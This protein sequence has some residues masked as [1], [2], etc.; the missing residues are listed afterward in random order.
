VNV[1]LVAIW[2]SRS[3]FVRWM[4]AW[5]DL[6]RLLRN[7]SPSPSLPVDVSIQVVQD[8]G[9]RWI[10]TVDFYFTTRLGCAQTAETQGLLTRVSS[11]KFQVTLDQSV[12]SQ[13][14]TTSHGS[15]VQV[16]HGCLHG[17]IFLQV[18]LG[19]CVESWVEQDAKGIATQSPQRQRGEGLDGGDVLSTRC[20]HIP[21]IQALRGGH[22]IV[23]LRTMCEQKKSTFSKLHHQNGSKFYQFFFMSRYTWYLLHSKNWYSNLMIYF[24]SR[25]Y[26]VSN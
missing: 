7:P 2:P 23:K 6:S 12:Q 9:Y 4:D 13:P 10:S 24:F 8:R 22:Y 17:N 11:P 5:F 3:S 19:T 18:R 21:A 25:K 16:L 20:H 15:S 14:T 26:T 1:F